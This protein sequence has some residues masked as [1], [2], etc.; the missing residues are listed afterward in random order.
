MG[1]LVRSTIHKNGEGKR[2]STY[3]VV[4]SVHE[5]TVYR[6][7]CFK[8]ITV[9]FLKRIHTAKEI[10]RHQYYSGH[11]QKDKILIT[12][13]FNRRADWGNNIISEIPFSDARISTLQKLSYLIVS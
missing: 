2:L 5:K 8:Y 6:R 7:C 9:D 11:D 4:Y 1:Q 13:S 12:F 3:I 10:K